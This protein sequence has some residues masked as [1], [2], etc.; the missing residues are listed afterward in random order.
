MKVER[1]NGKTLLHSV[2]WFGFACWAAT[3]VL[4][5]LP[6]QWDFKTYYFAA[7]AWL[8]GLNPYDPENLPLVAGV[9]KLPFL[10]PP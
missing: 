6:H 7:T 3:S 5:F 2:F 8:A 9:N 4:S 10:Y 1:L